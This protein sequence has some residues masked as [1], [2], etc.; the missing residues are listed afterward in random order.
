M[1]DAKP[2][3]IVG[4]HAE[5]ET[6]GTALRNA[7][8]KRGANL[9]NIGILA[10]LTVAGIYAGYQFFP[11]DGN[12]T[13]GTTLSLGGRLLIGV[14]LFLMAKSIAKL[15]HVLG[16]FGK[17]KDKEESAVSIIKAAGVLTVLLS[18][19]FS[20][21]GTWASRN[22]DRIEACAGNGDCESRIEDI[23]TIR[24]GGSI[25][26]PRGATRSFYILGTV[27]VTNFQNC[28][29]LE[30]DEDTFA[31]T[32]R[33]GGRFN[34]FKARSGKKELAVVT[35]TYDHSDPRC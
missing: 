29:Y 16:I 10:V 35:S 13:G 30:Y 31:V 6:E 3:G 17:D 23:P 28:H 5:A 1:A 34:D 14:I 33:A 12:T 7:E 4:T 9:R 19:V 18:L 26:I 25:K 22:I 11:S 2:T 20:G 21:F 27:T 15:L 8:H 24:D 32:P